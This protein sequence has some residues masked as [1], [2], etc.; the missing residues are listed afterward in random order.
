M[1]GAQKCWELK[2]VG[3]TKML[4]AQKCIQMHYAVSDVVLQHMF[5]SGSTCILHGHFL[6]HYTESLLI[7]LPQSIPVWNQA[8]HPKKWREN[9]PAI[10]IA[11]L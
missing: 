2:N 11:L 4:G 3:S 9:F 5:N 8:I 7:S 6:S 1:L 10:K